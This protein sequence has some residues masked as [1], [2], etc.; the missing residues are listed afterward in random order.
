MLLKP[1]NL[2]FE[3]EDL[4]QFYEFLRILEEVG[5][6]FDY[7]TLNKNNYHKNI[8]FNFLVYLFDSNLHGHM[9]FDIEFDIV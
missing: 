8:M 6:L 4:S 3:L 9:D 2:T 1:S 5:N 7:L